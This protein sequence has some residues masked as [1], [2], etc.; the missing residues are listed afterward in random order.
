MLIESGVDLESVSKIMGHASVSTT[1]NI[2][3]GEIESGTALTEF[4]SNNLNP[5]NI[6]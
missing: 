2:Y 1:I 3:C 5:I 4:V 6:Y